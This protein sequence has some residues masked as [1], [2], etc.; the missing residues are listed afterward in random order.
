MKTRV[1]KNEEPWN[2]SVTVST[3]LLLSV[4][5]TRTPLSNVQ[6]ATELSKQ[7]AA[8]EEVQCT[9]RKIMEKHEDYAARSAEMAESQRKLH[10]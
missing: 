9:E 2:H 1:Q 4:E 6:V 3:R 7:E 5:S 10:R 8:R